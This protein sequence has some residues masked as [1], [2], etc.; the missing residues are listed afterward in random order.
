MNSFEHIEAQDLGSALTALQDPQSAALA[1]GTDLV[2]ELKRGIRKPDRLI[3]LKRLSS[4]KGI[5][6][7]PGLRLGALTPLSEPARGRTNSS[8]QSRF[9][10]RKIQ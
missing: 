1:G 4:L 6:K 3:D 10:G 9:R 8:P 5:I 7:G 2:G